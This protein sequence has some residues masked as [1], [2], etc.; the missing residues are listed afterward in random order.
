MLEPVSPSHIPEKIPEIPQDKELE[1]TTNEDDGGGYSFNFFK[2]SKKKTK[3]LNST[4]ATIPNNA[5]NDDNPVNL[6]LSPE[7]LEK[8]EKL[9]NSRKKRST[10]DY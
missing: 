3:E 1:P 6:Q 4:N 8:M 2:K 7:A 10:Q 9:R 5:Y